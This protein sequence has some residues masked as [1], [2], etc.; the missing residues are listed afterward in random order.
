MKRTLAIVFICGLFTAQAGPPLHWQY[1]LP[2]IKAT[3]TI[4][5]TTSNKANQPG[6]KPLPRYQIPK[7]NVFC[8]M[9]DKLMKRTGLWLTVGPK[10]H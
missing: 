6:L 9:E 8:I 4:S 5:V 7:G 2:L 1:Y 3:K 10:A